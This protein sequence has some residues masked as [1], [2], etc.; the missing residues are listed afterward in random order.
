MPDMAEFQR[1]L[2]VAFNEPSLLEQA[3]V[4]SSFSNENPASTISHNERLEFLGDAVLDFIVA[5]KLHREFTKLTEGEMTKARATLVRRDTLAHIASD[6]KLGDFLYM[7]KGEESSGGRKKAPNL[8]G[9]L[10]A[11]IAAIYLDQGIETAKDVVNRLL[12]GEWE[13]LT[14]QGA[15]IEYKS[16]LQELTQSVFQSAPVYRLVSE[17]GPDHDKVFTVEVIID[18]KARGT[19]TG[20]SKK[21]AETEA[22]RLALETLK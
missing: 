6:I 12:A 16:K 7:G 4:H 3:L 18:G 15:D 9:A 22:A 10:E 14:S 19:G 5:D 8:A 13:K 11:I 2:G 21:I 17:T 1:I 20:K